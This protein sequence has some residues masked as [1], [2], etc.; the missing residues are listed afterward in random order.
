MNDIFPMTP[1]KEVTAAPRG[2]DPIVGTTNGDTNV[3]HCRIEIEVLS[4]VFVW[5]VRA[6]TLRF[7]GGE[8]DE[9]M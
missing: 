1:P 8:E 9:S 6:V 4:V 5:Y 2:P 3:Q 7:G